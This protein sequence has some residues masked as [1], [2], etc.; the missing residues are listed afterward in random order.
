MSETFFVEIWGEPAGIVV[1]EG[2]C[3][4]FHAVTQPFFALDGSKYATP[5]QAR[6]AAVS[7]DRERRMNIHSH[8]SSHHG[9]ATFHAL[10]ISSG[11]DAPCGILRP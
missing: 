7:M 8:A 4:R 11:G 2:N 10:S 5:G 6:L 3:F 1:K 9:K